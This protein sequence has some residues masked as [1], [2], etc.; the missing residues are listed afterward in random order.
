MVTVNV[1][2]ENMWKKEKK[3]GMKVKRKEDF[4]IF[5]VRFQSGA[6]GKRLFVCGLFVPGGVVKF[7]ASQ[8]SVKVRSGS[9]YNAAARYF[10]LA[11]RF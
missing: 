5:L 3:R 9:L 1:Q 8:S 2:R 11:P 7:Y 4:L 6:V 10:K